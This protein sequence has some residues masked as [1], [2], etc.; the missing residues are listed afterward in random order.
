MVGKGGLTPTA[1]SAWRGFGEAEFGEQLREALDQ[2]AF[3]GKSIPASPCCRASSGVRGAEPAAARSGAAL[4]GAAA[5]AGP[6]AERLIKGPAPL[7]A[8]S[9][10]PIAVTGCYRHNDRH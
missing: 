4:A 7:W 10:R 8:S 6:S 9:P 1:A 2:A 5:G 3:L